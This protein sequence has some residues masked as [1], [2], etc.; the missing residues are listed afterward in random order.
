ME[1]IEFKPSHG[2]QS[3]EIV[4]DSVEIYV[5]V[6]QCHHFKK[7]AEKTQ[8]EGIKTELQMVG[9]NIKCAEN[10]PDIG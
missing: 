3:T 7:I 10:S 9:I 8:P 6:S 1:K 5:P 4:E 2:Q